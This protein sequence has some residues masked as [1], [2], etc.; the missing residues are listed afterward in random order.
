MNAR[1][2]R[3]SNWSVRYRRLHLLFALVAAAAAGCS[4]KDGEEPTGTHSSRAFERAHA[5]STKV[6]VDQL[7]TQAFAQWSLNNDGCPS[8]IEELAALINK[9]P[10]DAYKR[11]LVMLCGDSAPAEVGGLGILSLGAD[12]ERGTSDDIVSWKRLG[13]P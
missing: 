7:A 5:Q 3:R 12:G 1:P 11:E 4:S 2:I 8:S 9:R 6:L 10:I 13:P